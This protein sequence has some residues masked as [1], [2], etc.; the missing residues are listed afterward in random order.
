MLMQKGPDEL[1]YTENMVLA[2]GSMLKFTGSREVKSTTK[3]Q[4]DWNY[5]KQLTASIDD[6]VRAKSDV[7]VAKISSKFR[8]KNNST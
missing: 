5:L 4:R 8:R 1:N 3:H 7:L 2:T 6:I